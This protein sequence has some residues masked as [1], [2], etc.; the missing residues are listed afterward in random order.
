MKR[1]SFIEG[2]FI[3]TLAIIIVKILGML[4]VIPFYAIIGVSGSA[5]YAY[6]Y[7][8]YVIFLDISTVGLPIAISK[9][10]N[11]FN[12]LGQ[13]DAKQRA[14]R[15]AMTFLRYVSVGIFI[16]LFIF[17]KP[18]AILIIG[19]L[20]GGNTIEMVTTAIRCVDF[21]ILIIPYLSIT[22]GYLQGH[23][24]INVSSVSNVLEQVIR[25]AFVLIGS[26]VTIKV[27]HKS[28]DMGVNVALLGAFFGGLIAYLYVKVKMKKH[29]DEFKLEEVTKKDAI[30]N[31]EIVKK[32]VT[33]AVPF[34]VI[35]CVSSIYSFV[36]MLL[37]M[38]SMEWLGFQTSQVEFIATSMSTWAPKINMII[39]SI[40]MGMTISLIPSI[41]SAF[42]L[43]KWDEVNHK[44]NA[45]LKMIIFI[46]LPM[47]IGLSFLSQA[48]WSVFYGANRVGGIIL[49]LSVFMAV[50][51]N[52]YMISSSILQSLNK[53][54]I[55]YISAIAGFVC[56]ALLDV[57]LI[58]LFNY[59][60][61]PSYLGAILASIL[62]YLLST[63]I[64]LSNIKR[65]NKEINYQETWNFLGQMMLPTISLILVLIAIKWLM[66]YNV[67]SKVASLGFIILNALV[68]GGVYIAVSYQ[69][70]LLNLVLGNKLF[71]K[72]KE[73]LTKFSK[74]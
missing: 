11:E 47:A 43:K 20:K 45:S 67:D 37:V 65:E 42:T 62:G 35:N 14:Y 32:I 23:N 44:T 18:I 69:M 4:Y 49:G 21:A 51:L 63:F 40:A 27:L 58:F 3:A 71:T 74:H 8:I 39:T 16:F 68:G 34:I 56:N 24:I 19:D 54:K 73:K 5:L 2:T 9:I 15:L 55:V 31:K 36:D 72:I 50:A 25:I 12:T 60:G 10:T 1:S 17:A 6:A 61:I 13:M 38:R 66:P 22:R 59:I 30:S 64:A 53:F 48:V 26:Y 52:L 46:S 28:Y 41:V 7:N 70:G 29:K 57:P 33:Y